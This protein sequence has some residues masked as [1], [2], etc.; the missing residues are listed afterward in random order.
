[1]KETVL[2]HYENK[3]RNIIINKQQ[4]FCYRASEVIVLSFL[5]IS[6]LTLAVINMLE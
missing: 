6:N 3:H 1:M 2:W 5:L 4:C